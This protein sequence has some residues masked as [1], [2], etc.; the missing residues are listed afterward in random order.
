MSDTI[1]EILVK[2]KGKTGHNLDNI[3]H[4]SLFESLSFIH[5]LIF[6]L[7]MAERRHGHFY[8]R[9]SVSLTGLSTAQLNSVGC[10]TSV[11]LF[12]LVNIKT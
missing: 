7:S 12:A 2:E 4:L 9:R 11:T 5:S 1:L 8:R 6:G 10:F 3:L